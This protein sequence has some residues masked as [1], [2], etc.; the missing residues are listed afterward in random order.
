MRAK[1]VFV[2]FLVVE[3]GLVN[4]S[5]PRKALVNINE[6]ASIE[7]LGDKTLLGDRCLVTLYEPADTTVDNETGESVV[8]GRRTL[9]VKETYESVKELLEKHATVVCPDT[10]Q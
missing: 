5:T 9:S 1:P 8:R 4:V 3:S 7:S 6:I 10:Y 2:E